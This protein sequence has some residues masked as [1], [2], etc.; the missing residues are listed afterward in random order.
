MLFLIRQYFC[1]L[2]LT[3]TWHVFF[4]FVTVLSLFSH[5]CWLQLCFSLTSHKLNSCIYG[6]VTLFLI[7]RKSVARFRRLLRSIL[8]KNILQYSD[9][10]FRFSKFILCHFL[11]SVSHIQLY[12]L[13]R[14]AKLIVFN[15]WMEWINSISK[16]VSHLSCW[17]KTS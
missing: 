10:R 3:A 11:F 14:S 17:T 12:W 7:M 13:I 5:F 9:T 6:F 4:L 15:R 2:T 8:C 1:W 16:Q